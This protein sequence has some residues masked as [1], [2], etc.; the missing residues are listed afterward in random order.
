[1]VKPQR[2][3]AN[4]NHYNLLRTIEANFGLCALGAGDAGAKAITSVW[5]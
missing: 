5:K 1:M 2:V 4:Y 3:G